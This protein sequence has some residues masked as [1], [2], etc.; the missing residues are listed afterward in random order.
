MF[1]FSRLYTQL[2]NLY[3]GDKVL[4]D[5]TNLFLNEN[6][7]E[8]FNELKRSIF[9]AFGLIMQNIINT[10]FRKIPYNELFSN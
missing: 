9:D 7:E 2:D 8:I 10:V 4:G 3:N 1:L 6:W 5:T